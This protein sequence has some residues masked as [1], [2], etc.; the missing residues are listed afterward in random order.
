MQDFDVGGMAVGKHLVLL[1]LAVVAQVFQGVV[2]YRPAVLV[3][4][5]DVH[6]GIGDRLALV[7][8]QLDEEGVVLLEE[9]RTHP[10]EVDELAVL[11]LGELEGR[12]EGRHV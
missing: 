12:R 8:E 11:M 1:V 7:V 9:S 4:A 2:V 6:L 10:V 5:V 3:Y